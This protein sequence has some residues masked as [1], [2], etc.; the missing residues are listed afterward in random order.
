MICSS[1]MAILFLAVGVFFHGSL[2]A[3]RDSQQRSTM[4]WG[5]REFMQHCAAAIRVSDYAAPYD[6]T[7][8]VA[9]TLNYQFQNG[10][11]PGYPHAGLPTSGGSGTAGIQ[12]LKQHPD[13]DDPTASPT[14]PIIVTYWFDAPHRQILST[15]QQ[16]TNAA[17]APVVVC[18]C[19]QSVAFYLQPAPGTASGRALRRAVI[20]ISLANRDANGNAILQWGGQN[21]TLDLAEAAW[22]RRNFAAAD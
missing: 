1:I 8:S 18:S 16:G 21:L 12:I 13:S 6:P 20:Q 5:A 4:L 2:N 17:S 14:N 19:V 10:G 11:V 9:S 3:Y 22:P 15:R 7:P